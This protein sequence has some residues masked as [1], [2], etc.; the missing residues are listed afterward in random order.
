MCGTLTENWLHG[1]IDRGPISK[2]DTILIRM[3]LSIGVLHMPN[4]FPLV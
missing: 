2:L 4:L 3:I 1:V